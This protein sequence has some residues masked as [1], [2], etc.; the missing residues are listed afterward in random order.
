MRKHILVSPACRI[1]HGEK[2]RGGGGDEGEIASDCNTVNHAAVEV[3][4]GQMGEVTGGQK[5]L[6]YKSNTAVRTHLKS[7]HIQ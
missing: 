4:G 7:H 2:S 1:V 6:A 5:L 3:T